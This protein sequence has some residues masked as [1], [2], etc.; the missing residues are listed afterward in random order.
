M[1]RVALLGELTVEVNGRGVQLPRARRA[2]LVLGWLALHPG[3]HSRASV[4]ARFWPDVVDATAKASLRN[5][6]WSLRR[7]A[8]VDLLATSRERVGL[9]R[10]VWVDV[11]AF[12]ELTQAGSLEDAAALCRGELLSGVDDEWVHD[13]REAHRRRLSHTL[14]ALAA[15]AES[16]GDRPWAVELSRRRAGLDPLD[17]DAH[18]AL[19]ARLVAAGDA[20]AAVMCFERH[21][22]V[23]RRELGIPPSPAVCGLV[24]DLRVRS[25]AA[26]PAPI[27][28]RTAAGTVPSWAPGRRFPLPPRLAIP[29]AA[30]FVG[31]THELGVLR[32]AWQ[33]AQMGAGP[34][35]VVVGGEAGIGKSRLGRELA[36]QVRA[37]PAVVLHGTAQEDAIA[38]LLPFIEAIGHLVRVAAPDELARLLGGRLADLGRLFP[39]LSVAQTGPS[40]D[41]IGRYRSLDTVAELLARVSRSAPV[42]LLLDDLQ[43]A[44]SATSGL[45]RHVVESRPGARLL[46]VATCREDVVPA[47]G[48]LRAALD[49][50]DHGH[51]V[52]RIRLTGIDDADAAGLA[53]GVIGQELAPELLA[54]VQ[55]EA[56]GNPFFVQELARHLAETGST[57]LLALLRAEVPTTAREVIGHRIA[58]L[59]ADCAQLLTIGAVLGREFDLPLLGEMTPL[60]PPAVLSALDA[61]TDAGLLVELSGLGERFA[62]AHAL[63]HRALRDRLTRAHR[64]RLHARIADA[65]QRS[66]R[67]D[68]RDVAYHLCEAGSAGDIATAVDFAE[69]AA[70]GALGNL[71]HAEAVELYTRA[72]VLLPMD[73]PRTRLLSVRRVLAYQALAH[74]TLDVRRPTAGRRPG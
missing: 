32:E 56:G 67:A 30:T 26:V 41:D 72:I 70:E 71:A 74:A 62:F 49:R 42:L 5:A 23:L 14:E 59:G 38:S 52:R 73:D 51:L 61:A 28:Q 65:L 64:R 3:T 8:G 40:D 48:H 24:S 15:R 39:E 31:R 9:A 53:H 22:D 36:M 7:A 57:S 69:R 1:L 11:V 37:A 12:G 2:R 44:D 66:G 13:A 58:R 4:A 43:W 33:D 16:A 19:I 50:L 25:A 63:V 54:I 60:P 68:L 45:I 27:P 47:S 29:Q 10:S 34:H 21:R 35:L 20:V 6:L 18:A 55:D 17:E 46:V